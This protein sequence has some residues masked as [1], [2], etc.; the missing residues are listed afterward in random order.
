MIEE[1]VG[2]WQRLIDMCVGQR[3]TAC[4]MVGVAV[5]SGGCSIR[6]VA[7]NSLADALA[8]G[9][10]VYASDNDP[11][12]VREALP[13]FL[14]TLETLLV[15]APDNPGLLVSACS[16]FTTYAAAFIQADAEVAEWAD[17]DYARAET[18]TT[19]ALNLYIRARDYCLRRVELDH[20]GI[21]DLLRLEPENAVTVF[22]IDDVDTLYWLGASWGLAI[23]IG[24]DRPALSADLPAVRA[25]MERALVLDEDYNRGALHAAFIALE[26]LPDILG[27]SPERA[28]E[29]FGRALE[30]SGGRD[31]SVY[32]SFATG[33]AV[34]TQDRVEF[35]SLL[36]S[37]LAIDP[38]SDER[39]RLTNIVAQR[40]ARLLLDHIDELFDPPL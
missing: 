23:S 40:R 10:S 7:V 28:R 36:Q 3:G 8:E 15:S 21:T 30:R 17:F 24:L 16:T 19:R 9:V 31:A 11:E 35:E 22:S 34:P 26:S 13:F 20:P 39:I 25:L 32:V 4:V 12:L 37:A 33:V 6:T 1:S 2:T 14:K 18:L 38:D 29:H 27:G 5:L